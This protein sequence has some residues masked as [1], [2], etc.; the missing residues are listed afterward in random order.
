M[1]G[2]SRSL[3]LDF[4]RGDA[5]P[6]AW[7]FTVGGGALL[8]V[9]TGLRL[10]LPH[11]LADRYADAQ[12]DD[13]HGRARAAYRWRP[14]LTLS[15][16]ARFSHG[17]GGWPGTAGFGFWNAPFATEMASPLALRAPSALWFFVA[18]PP[19][20]LAFAPRPGW[21]GRG[22]FAQSVA[23]EVAAGLP[24]LA[25]GAKLAA[26]IY[27]RS[28]RALLPRR[29]R[30]RVAEQPLLALD[31]TAWHDYQI[32][33]ERDHATLA[34]DGETVLTS[35]APSAGPL[36]LVV[37]VDNQWAALG[38]PTGYRGGLHAFTE[39]HWLELATLTLEER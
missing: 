18:G 1:N 27:L 38:P 34:V 35:S 21:Q 3:A 5:P 29:L 7:P 37:W 9:A 31:I 23:L 28:T 25:L 17:A 8:R 13:F 16:R 10:L 6:E 4:A 14:P 15:L 39:P 12:L 30:A 33:W 36:A 32:A 20:R 26:L 24:G 2:S 22:A 19:T 11:A